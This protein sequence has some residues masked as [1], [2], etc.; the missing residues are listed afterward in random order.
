MSPLSGRPAPGGADAVGAL[1]LAA[2]ATWFAATVLSQ[3]PRPEF[4]RLAAL[5]G[6]GAL[7]PNWR[8]FAPE[9]A[10]HDFHVLFRT[11]E[12]DGRATPWQ[13][14]SAI[15]PRRPLHTV[16]FP[17]RRREKALY[18]LCHEL[19]AVMRQFDG[20]LTQAP[21]YRM[22]RNSVARTVAE[23]PGPPPRGFQ[24]VVARHTG[25]DP[26]HDP[27]YLFVSPYIPF[28]PAAPYA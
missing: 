17:N 9:P 5:D 6:T 14:G 11:E 22:L 7:I 8:F 16:W 23:R 4:N 3:H 26:A 19:V 1:A 13:E 12:A 25:H 10:R 21:A 27:D 18:D 20:D 28:T 24:F 2:L 15:T